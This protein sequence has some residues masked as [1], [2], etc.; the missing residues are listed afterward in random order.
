MVTASSLWYI[1]NGIGF[2]STGLSGGPNSGTRSLQIF[3]K[4]EYRL[5]NFMIPYI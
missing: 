3:H 2:R 1:G 4:I 5:G